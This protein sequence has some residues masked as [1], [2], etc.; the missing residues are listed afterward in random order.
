MWK[1]ER[2]RLWLIKKLGGYPEPVV[3]AVAKTEVPLE[4]FSAS[5]RICEPYSGRLE[6]CCK[7][8]ALRCLFERIDRDGF[9]RWETAFNEFNGETIVRATALLVNANNQDILDYKIF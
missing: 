9:I 5:S 4:K 1:F 3:R 2:I 7:A 6:Q 8:Q